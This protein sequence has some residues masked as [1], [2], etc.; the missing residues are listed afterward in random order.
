MGLTGMNLQFAINGY[1]AG[2]SVYIIS[3]RPLLYFTAPCL[4]SALIKI[5]RAAIG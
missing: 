5:A 2:L 3:N 1:V 4:S